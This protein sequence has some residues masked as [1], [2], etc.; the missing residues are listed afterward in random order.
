ML[1]F[2]RVAHAAARRAGALLR[3]R[4]TERHEIA[5][6][7][8]PIDLVTD[9]DRDAEALI[10]AALAEAFPEHGIVA[11][12]SAARPSRDGHHWYVDPLD[13]TTNFAH[14]YPQF[15]VSIALARGD[16][17]LVG[18]VYDPVRDEAFSAVR[19]EGARLN[20]SPIA[21]SS[22]PR[23]EQALLATGFPYDRRQHAEH[24]VAFLTEGMRRAQGV[25]REGSAAL[26]LCWLASGRLDGYW[27]EKL[28]PWDLAAGRLVVEEAGGRVTD[29]AGGPHRLSG[30]ETAASNGRIHAELLAMLADVARRRPL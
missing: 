27:E 5:F 22:V 17:L 18:V 6:K 7:S 12:E 8:G 29:F 16:E 21:V 1:A 23:L 13:G 24:Y 30:E 26:D 28:K 10:V 19:G 2:E 14:G 9:A 15:A 11:E 3:A 20:G 25:R 4:Y